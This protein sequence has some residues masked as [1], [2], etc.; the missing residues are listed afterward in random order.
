LRRNAYDK[1][2]SVVGSKLVWGGSQGLVRV[3]QSP[4]DPLVMSQLEIGAHKIHAVFDKKEGF[5]AVTQDYWPPFGKAPAQ[6]IVQPNALPCVK[7]NGWS[8]DSDGRN[9]QCQTAQ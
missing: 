5:S 8:S 3:N 9:H 1:E 4:E 7:V 2:G 6:C